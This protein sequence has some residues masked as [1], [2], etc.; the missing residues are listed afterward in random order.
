MSKMTSTGLIV[1]VSAATPAT[2]DA[3]GFA[4][5]SY[6]TVGGIT[7]VS[8]FGAV[9]AVVESNPLATGVVEKY[10]GFVNWGS[11]TLDSDYDPDD[12]GQAIFED[13]VEDIGTGGAAFDPVSLKL[14]YQTGAVRYLYGKCFSAPENPGSTNSMVT[15]SINVEIEKAPVRVAAP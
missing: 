5:L 15:R 4:A 1:A 9:A 10:K 12:A 11:V 14:T 3:A 7:G 2:F 13:A 8:A 6:T